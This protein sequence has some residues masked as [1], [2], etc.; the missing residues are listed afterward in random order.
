MTGQERISDAL[1]FLNDGLLEE[2][3][4]V[5]RK[6]RR[7][8]RIYHWAAACACLCLA[9]ILAVFIRNSR[10]LGGSADPSQA[11]TGIAQVPESETTEAA[12]SE[13]T[14]TAGGSEPEAESETMPEADENLPLLAW[15]E[16]RLDSMGFGGYM[17]YDISEVV[18]GNPWDDSASLETLPVYRN[19]ASASVWPPEVTEERLDEMTGFL[20]EIAA[21]LGIPEDELV[22]AD[23]RPG[24]EK[25]EAIEKKFEDTGETV[26][27]ELYGITRVTADLGNVKIDVLY[28]MTAEIHFTPAEKLPEIY[29]FSHYASYDEM[30]A[31]AEYLKETYQDLL[32]M[33]NP[34]SNIYGGDYDFYGQQFYSLGFY[35]GA[36]TLEEQIVQ[37]NFN[38]AQF[39]CDDEGNLFLVRIS[40]PDL[41]EKIGDYPLIDREEAEAFLLEGTYLTAASYEISDPEL[42]YG[43]ELVYLNSEASGYFIPCYMFY[44]ELPEEEENGLKH[45]G[46]YYVPAVDPSYLTGETNGLDSSVQSGGIF[47]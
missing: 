2:A 39:Y 5:R 40:R 11:P 29:D 23:D 41:S 44:A 32:A 14:G 22:I 12:E 45:Y 37:Y 28:D 42:I 20:K 7:Q 26:P 16:F 8:K 43:G 36:G 46:I 25:R 21:R 47:Q 18:N 27:E 31:A 13:Q 9:G 19:T 1:Q 6:R 34:Q 4:R 30:Q 38:Q 35:E 10:G 17:A 3:E 15:E 24:T 33:E